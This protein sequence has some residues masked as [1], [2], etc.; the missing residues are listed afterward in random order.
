MDQ[1]MNTDETINIVGSLHASHPLHIS[2][3][4]TLIIISSLCLLIYSHVSISAALWFSTDSTL[5]T[6]G[7]CGAIGFEDV[8]EVSFIEA[9]RRTWDSGAIFLSLLIFICSGV[10]PYLKL[11]TLLSVWFVPSSPPRRSTA[12]SWLCSLGRWSL[13]D[14]YAILVVK[15]SA[16]FTL[17]GS[18]PVAVNVEIR[19][20]LAAFAATA[21]ASMLHAE[22]MQD[23]SGRNVGVVTMSATTQEGEVDSVTDED[24]ETLQF[25]QQQTMLARPA[26]S[27][28]SKLNALALAALTAVM[29]CA[30]SIPLFDVEIGGLIT[31]IDDGP[32]INRN[33][34]A[35]GII[36]ALA[37]TCSLSRT[38]TKAPVYFL[39]AIYAVIVLVLPPMALV[40]AAL[41]RK[42]LRSVVAFLSLDVL[43]LAVVLMT[44]KLEG[45]MQTFIGPK[46]E[47]IGVANCLKLTG[48]VGKGS[49]LMLAAALMLTGGFSMKFTK[50][51]GIRER[52]EGVCK[53]RCC[54]SKNDTSDVLELVVESDVI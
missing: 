12:L 53:E 48:K 45:L 4:S 23:V 40:L 15:S 11:I 6:T 25:L 21:V 19:P 27:R 1:V 35:G 3:L 10:W 54:S 31:W 36:R 39:V 49:W 30:Y 13:F 43:F 44:P 42:Y 16:D 47:E 17:S 7:D 5:S 20:G 37:S 33:F 18:Q 34:T 38:P 14:V 2:I 32:D 29:A 24:S 28:G 9:V 52:A 8:Y 51:E 50:C 26:C 46:C 41:D 22:W